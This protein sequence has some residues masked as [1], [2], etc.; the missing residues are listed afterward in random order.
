MVATWYC[1]KRAILPRTARPTIARP[2][3][4]QNNSNP[5][6]A[7]S[8]SLARLSSSIRR[9]V[10]ENKGKGKGKGRAETGH[11]A[12]EGGIGNARSSN[13]HASTEGTA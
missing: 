9:E 1:I 8:G 10:N 12:T 13:E 3:L 4:E 11:E 5:Q 2:D 6:L 7:E